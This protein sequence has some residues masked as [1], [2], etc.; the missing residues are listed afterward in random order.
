[1]FVDRRTL[2]KLPIPDWVRS[3]LAPWTVPAG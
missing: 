3:G 2:G 1:V